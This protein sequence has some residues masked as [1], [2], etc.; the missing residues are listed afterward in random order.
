[1]YICLLLNCSNKMLAILA[2]IFFFTFVLKYLT[3]AQLMSVKKFHT[4]VF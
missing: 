4:Y 3:T 2:S 1:M